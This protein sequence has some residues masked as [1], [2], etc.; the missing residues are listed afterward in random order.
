MAWATRFLKVFFFSVNT[1]SDV[2][3]SFLCQPNVEGSCGAAKGLSLSLP[4][5][6]GSLLRS[7]GTRELLWETSLARMCLWLPGLVLGSSSTV[8]ADAFPE[9]QPDAN[10]AARFQAARLDVWQ[11][12]KQM[13]SPV[14]GSAERS[15]LGTQMLGTALLSRALQKP[16]GFSVLFPT[17]PDPLGSFQPP[18]ARV[19]G[20]CFELPFIPWEILWPQS[21][22]KPRRKRG[23]IPIP[24]IFFL[25]FTLNH[26]FSKTCSAPSPA[27]EPTFSLCLAIY[28]DLVIVLSELPQEVFPSDLDEGI[29]CTLREFAEDTELGGSADP[30]EG[31]QAPRRDLDGLE[32][33]AEADRVRFSKAQGRVPRLGHNS[34]A[35]R[36]RLG[37]ERRGSSAAGKDLGVLVDSRLDRSRQGGQGGQRHPG[38]CRQ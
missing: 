17:S 18:L 24:S 29:E 5:R 7:V 12:D 16:V 10:E 23:F 26:V 2:F 20:G 30:L 4:C 28:R 6:L 19:L 13:K 36:G 27:E 31:R 14:V 22:C 37:A 9:F 25:T 1:S 21:L 34:P 3:H 15:S 35:R 32:R 33:W 11:S 38:L 8:L